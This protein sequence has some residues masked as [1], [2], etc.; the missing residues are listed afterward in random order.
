M[1]N[2]RRAWVAGGAFFFTLVADQRRKLFASAEARTILGAALRK[3]QRERPF[4]INAIVLL[5]D[6]LH[7]IWSLPRGDADYSTRWGLIKATFTKRWLAGA[8]SE[9]KISAA[10]QSERRRQRAC[11]VYVGMFVGGKPADRT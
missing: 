11:Q 5:P 9:T 7:A 3:C 1:P 10:R 4:E 6:H 8:A 2:Y